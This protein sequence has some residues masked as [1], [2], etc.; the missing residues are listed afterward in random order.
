MEKELHKSKPYQFANSFE[1]VFIKTPNNNEINA[2][3]FN[4]LNP[5]ELCCFVTEIREFIK[6]G[7][8]SSVFLAYNYD[9]LVFDY[10]S[11][12]K[13]TGN[14]N[15][16][17]MYT[18]AEAVYDYDK[19]A[20]QR[21]KYVVYGYSL[22]GTFATRIASQNNPKELVL[23]APFYNLKKQFSTIQELHQLFY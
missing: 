4:R 15:E 16:E 17:A 3:H 5:K 14:F 20:V 9:V 21:R 10:R 11:Y 8:S 7:A 2:L 22:G 1:E 12:G 23:E 18:D 19:K 13:S 6:M